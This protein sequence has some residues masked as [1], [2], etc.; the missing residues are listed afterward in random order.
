MKQYA[1]LARTVEDYK[2]NSSD[3]QVS[4]MIDCIKVIILDK[5]IKAFTFV[6]SLKDY[7]TFSGT[8]H[9]VHLHPHE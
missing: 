7:W 5:F 2:S 9:Q 8:I 4:A 1:L 3:K 6:D